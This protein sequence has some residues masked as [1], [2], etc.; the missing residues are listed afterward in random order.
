MTQ[1]WYVQFQAD[2]ER[3]PTVI[4]PRVTRGDIILYGCDSSFLVGYATPVSHHGGTHNLS[5]VLEDRPLANRCRLNAISCVI[6]EQQQQYLVI[7]PSHRNRR[8]T[9][10][11][12]FQ[13]I[14]TVSFLNDAFL[15]IQSNQI[16]IRNLH[17][18][19]PLKTSSRICFPRPSGSAQERK[20]FDFRQL[21]LCT[22]GHCRIYH[23]PSAKKYPI[24]G[25]NTKDI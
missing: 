25:I 6:L 7:E 8:S 2:I 12:S 22:S 11:G 17:I 16:P 4:F 18:S 9:Q 3:N 5:L 14:F 15:Y 21:L 24:Y 23:S 20:R 13:F 10:T 1:K 19:A